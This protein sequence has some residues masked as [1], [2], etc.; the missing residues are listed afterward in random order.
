MIEIL[1]YT[2]LGLLMLALSTVGCVTSIAVAMIAM[3]ECVK[4]YNRLRR[5]FN[6]TKS[7]PEC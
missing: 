5:R 7:N 3:E 1:F 2:F 6:E 4:V